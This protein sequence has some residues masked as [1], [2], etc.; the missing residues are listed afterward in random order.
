MILQRLPVNQKN[1]A[2]GFLHA[3]LQLVRAI[4]GHAA[5]DT[6]RDRKRF[7]ETGLLIRFYIENG[8]FEYH[9]SGFRVPGKY[10]AGHFSNVATSTLLP[11]M[12][13]NSSAVFR[14]HLAC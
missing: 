7:F 9:V 14:P 12:R 4:A 2:A 3:A 6:L 11:D 8:D 10:S 1:V 13:A 5:N